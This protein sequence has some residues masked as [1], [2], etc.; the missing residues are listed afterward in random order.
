MTMDEG[1]IKYSQHWHQA[2]LPVSDAA[3]TLITA[4]QQLLKLGGIGV[5]PNGIGYGNVSIRVQDNHFL[6]TASATGHL[7][8]IG[9]DQLCEVTATDIPGNT[10]W[11]RGNMP[12]SSESM[13]HAAIYQAA[14]NI[15]AVVHI[16]HK[17]LW[18]RLLFKAPTVSDHVQYGT[19][20]MAECIAQLVKAASGQGELL[21]TAGHEDGIFSFGEDMQ[22]AL[23][24]IQNSL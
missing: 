10:L 8:V 11:C 21:V 14:S 22:E 15:Q 19:P 23:Q 17:Q 24:L 3:A 20:E 6:I 1:Y 18:T 9:V 13:T 16:H 5:Y 7:P 2:P 12:A 4:R